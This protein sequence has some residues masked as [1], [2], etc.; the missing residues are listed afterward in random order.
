MTRLGARQAI[1]TVGDGCYAKLPEDGSPALVRVRVAEQEARSPI[2]S[3]DAFLAGYLAALYSGRERLDALRYAVACGAESTRHF[4]AGV[5]DPAS[6][7]RLLDEVEIG[8]LELRAQ[9][10]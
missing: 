10:G 8:H 2:G 1:M 5:V 6:V 4:G 3:G 9:I 7:E